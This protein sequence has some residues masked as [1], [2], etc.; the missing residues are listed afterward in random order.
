MRVFIAVLTGALLSVSVGCGGDDDDDK[1]EKG[2]ADP[3]D[4]GCVDTIAADCPTGPPDQATCV[5]QCRALSTGACKTDYAAFQTCAKGKAI[6]CGSNGIPT[7]E[8]CST[9]QAA[10]IACLSAG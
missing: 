5:S 6:T 4:Q 9:E 1:D 2:G 8:E 10:F 7:V 3:C